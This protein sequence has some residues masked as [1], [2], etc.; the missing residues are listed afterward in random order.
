LNPE[1]LARMTQRSTPPIEEIELA[2]DTTEPIRGPEVINIEGPDTYLPESES[3]F[4][5]E[6]LNAGWY[7]SDPFLNSDPSL[8]EEEA[9]LQLESPNESALIQPSSLDNN[10]SS[11][12]LN[13][14]NFESVEQCFTVPQTQ[15]LA[16]PVGLP[17]CNYRDPIEEK[18]SVSPVEN[19]VST[20]HSVASG[21][22]KRANE[23]G[24]NLLKKDPKSILNAA[25]EQST[26]DNE[27]ARL[28]RARLDTRD[29]PPKNE[30]KYRPPPK[31]DEQGDAPPAP[32]NELNPPE[33]P[34][35]PPERV[36][37]DNPQ[38][39]L[40]PCLIPLYF[41]I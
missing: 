8:P 17:P 39:N 3:I 16:L 35:N 20:S 10:R 41:F 11:I 12:D 30:Y 14:N 4:T 34:E 25:H 27:F 29:P 24:P 33:G 31:P 1:L 36:P 7:Q 23:L 28:K 38:H 5:D 15:H 6:K 18:V 32:D 21:H 19:L 22:L 13:K 9:R 26:I 37:R 2:D 40:R